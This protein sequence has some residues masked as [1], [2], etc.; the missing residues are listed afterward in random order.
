[1]PWKRAVLDPRENPAQ[2]REFRTFRTVWGLHHRR[3][4]FRKFISVL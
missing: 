4:I 3:Y 1:L 2:Y